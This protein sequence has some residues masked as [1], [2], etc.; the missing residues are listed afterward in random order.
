MAKLN[1]HRPTRGAGSDAAVRP[2][3]VP[4]VLLAI[5]LG[6]YVAVAFQQAGA[7]SA[8]VVFGLVLLLGVIETIVGI[9]VAYAVAMLMGTNF[10]EL[11]AAFVKFAGIFIFTGAL[12]ALIPF[13]GLLALLVYLLLLIWLFELE[14]FEAIVFAIVLGLVRLALASLIFAAIAG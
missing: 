3:L 12:S 11:K 5:G 6:L 4:L 1:Y 10:G 14:M 8:A 13:G 2:Y 9:A 7:R